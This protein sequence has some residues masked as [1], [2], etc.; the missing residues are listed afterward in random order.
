MRKLLLLALLLCKFKLTVNIDTEQDNDRIEYIPDNIVALATRSSNN[1]DYED[2]DGNKKLIDERRNWRKKALLKTEHH[3]DWDSKR[4]EFDNRYLDESD[5]KTF[6]GMERPK[7]LDMSAA[8]RA[9]HHFDDVKSNMPFG[10]KS[11]EVPHSSNF[12]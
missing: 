3:K 4:H 9:P 2:I 10:M 7:E 11:S 1:Y 5:T 8:Y 6:S 12:L